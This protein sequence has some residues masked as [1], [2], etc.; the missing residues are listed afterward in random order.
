MVTT[1]W[2]ISVT[3][4]YMKSVLSSFVYNLFVTGIL[5][6]IEILFSGH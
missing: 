5:V 3:E 2:K 1:I 6:H 4:K